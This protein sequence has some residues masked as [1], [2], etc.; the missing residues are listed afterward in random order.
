LLGIT[1]A[2]YFGASTKSSINLNFADFYFGLDPTIASR[3]TLFVC[4][5]VSGVVVVFPALDTISVF[6][7][8]ANTLGNNLYSAAGGESI[9]MVAIGLHFISFTKVARGKATAHWTRTRGKI[10]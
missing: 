1:A 8:I 7:L 10:C 6:P 5:L 3:V 2:S 4:R 9:K